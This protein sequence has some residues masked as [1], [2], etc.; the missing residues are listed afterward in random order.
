MPE[1]LISDD[2]HSLIASGACE[3]YPD[4]VR[5]CEALGL[6]RLLDAFVSPRA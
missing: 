5:L 6:T 2:N 1:R 3:K 4:F